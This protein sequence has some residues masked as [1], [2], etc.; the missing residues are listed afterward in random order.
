MLRAGAILSR[1]RQNPGLVARRQG[2]HGGC[3]DLGMVVAA[4]GLEVRA[5]LEFVVAFGLDIEGIVGGHQGLGGDCWDLW[6]GRRGFLAGRLGHRWWSSVPLE[7]SLVPPDASIV[8]CCGQQLHA[9]NICMAVDAR[10]SP[11]GEPPS[12]L[13]GGH[14]P[15]NCTLQCLVPPPCMLRSTPRSWS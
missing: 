6:N 2:Y 9:G 10:A 1:A 14:L 3:Q 15:I 4:S 11:H 7:W 8:A 13:Q 5:V 12:R